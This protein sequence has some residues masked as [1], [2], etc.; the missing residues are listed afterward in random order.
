MTRALRFVAVLVA[1]LLGTGLL[2]PSPASAADRPGGWYD[3]GI[4][5]TQVVNCIGLIQ[6][7][8]YTEAGIGAYAGY[9]ADPDSGV[10]AVGQTFWI[11]YSVHGLG[12]PCLGGTYFRPRIALPPGVVFDTSQQIRCGYNGSGGP[13]PMQGCPGWGNLT[14]G[15]YSNNRDQG[16]WGVAQGGRWEFQFPVRATQP[17]SGAN[18]NISLD[19][20]D[21]NSDSTVALRAPV[22]VFAVAGGGGT[23]ATPSYQVLYDNPSTVAAT[24]NPDGGV[25]P[26]G[27]VSEFQAITNN[28]PGV[29]RIEF[30]TGLDQ[31]TYQVEVP[32]PANFGSSVYGWTDWAP[33]ASLI[34]P[35]RKN[36]WRGAFTP[37]GGSTVYG[38]LQT[39]T[40]ASSG[41]GVT[42]TGP[43]GGTTGGTPGGLSGSSGTLGGTVTSLK[44]AARVSAKAVGKAPTSRRKAK[45]QVV[46]KPT[47]GV[48]SGVVTV[49]EKGRKVGSGTLRGGKVVVSLKKLKAGKHRLVVRYG[50][51]QATSA[52]STTLVI[53]VRR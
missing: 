50:G 40:I 53:R 6:G 16:L 28:R 24:H 30:A 18:L 8:P 15:T 33:F 42:G 37:T 35:G 29:L 49:T 14:N 20:L 43:I 48:A 44:V 7:T 4:G 51:S 47:R 27:I 10:P 17:V 9:W 22:Y 21:G 23:P 25:T 32:V 1:L 34:V 31:P 12:N 36:Y 41:S 13:A 39:F 38:P 46:V 3:G 11:H 45:V 26:Y 5:Y 2:H 19:T 52:A